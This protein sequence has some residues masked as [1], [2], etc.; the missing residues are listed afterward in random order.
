MVCRPTKPDVGS[1]L[2][3]RLQPHTTDITVDQHDACV[4]EPPGG[5]LP[6]FTLGAVKQVGGRVHPDLT[7]EQGLVFAPGKHL[8]HVAVLAA[9]FFFADEAKVIVGRRHVGRA[10][11]LHDVGFMFQH[12][13]NDPFTESRAAGLPDYELFEV[14]RNE[15]HIRNHLRLGRLLFFAEQ[16]IVARDAVRAKASP[17]FRAGLGHADD[18]GLHAWDCVPGVRYCEAHPGEREQEQHRNSLSRNQ[19]S[20]S[21]VECLLPPSSQ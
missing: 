9:Q 2:G 13:T 7:A 10:V 17:V 21:Q 5:R 16:P 12:L 20:C 14:G 19:L 1:G 6:G 8:Q 4:P 18:N 15:A 3:S 11:I